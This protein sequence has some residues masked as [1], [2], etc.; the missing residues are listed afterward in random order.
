MARTSE[1]LCFALVIFATLLAF[2]HATSTEEVATQSKSFLKSILS[3]AIMT[4]ACYDEFLSFYPTPAC[5]SSTASKVLG[6]GI[7]AGSFAL[8]FPQIISIVKAKSAEGM[9]LSA[10]YLETSSTAS[11]SLYNFTIGTPLTTYAESVVILIQ[12]IILVILT[13]HFEKV[14]ILDILLVIVGA[15]TYAASHFAIPPQFFAVMIILSTVTSM[16]G[17]ITQVYNYYKDKS[18]GVLSLTTTIMQVA[19]TAARV[20]TT[21]AEVDD[22]AILTS[23]LLSF[24]LNVIILLQIFLYWDKK[25]SMTTVLASEST[26]VKDELSKLKSQVNEMKEIVGEKI[27][28]AKTVAGKVIAE[29]KEALKPKSE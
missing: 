12:N 19:G 15:I 27:D 11:T 26:I 7:I 23:F 8:K 18:T 1:L 22:V 28:E 24:A 3:P 10:L 2:V 21:L 4:P 9:I 16:S 20:F 14:P 13:W 25:E 29:K 17:R 6:L 5:I